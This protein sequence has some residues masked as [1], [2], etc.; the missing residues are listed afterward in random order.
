MPSN[1]QP[2]HPETTQAP[3]DHPLFGAG[4]VIQTA[5]PRRPKHDFVVS[6]ISADADTAH[7]VDSVSDA[8]GVHLSEHTVRDRAW[9][10]NHFD[11]TRITGHAFR[12]DSSH[13]NTSQA[14]HTHPLDGAF[15]VV[16]ALPGAVSTHDFH[17]LSIAAN[18][19]TAQ[20]LH[21]GYEQFTSRFDI[22]LEFRV[23]SATRVGEHIDD[24][25]IRLSALGTL[26][27]HS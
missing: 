4:F 16:E 22:P 21:T 6:H 27:T 3:E 5:P 14:D 23:R 24:T 12:V 20:Q 2:P 10:I 18:K 15:C 13:P 7:S 1:S 9:L 11:T 26:R 17:L 25:F 8:H 19:E